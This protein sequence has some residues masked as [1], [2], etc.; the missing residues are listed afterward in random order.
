MADIIPDIG[1]AVIVTQRNCPAQTPQ[2]HVIL[3]SV[4]AAQTDVGEDLR[5]VDAHL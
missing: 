5:V 2:G 4:E 1:G 3:L